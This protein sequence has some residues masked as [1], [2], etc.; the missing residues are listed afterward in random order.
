MSLTVTERELCRELFEPEITTVKLLEECLPTEIFQLLK[1][2]DNLK[3][4]RD[5]ILFFDRNKYRPY[6]S[7]HITKILTN[8]FDCSKAILELVESLTPPFLIYLDMHFTFEI[9]KKDSD[10]SG[11]T[12]L[13]FQ[14]ASKASAFNST[15]KISNLKDLESLTEEIEGKNYSDLL[16]CVFAHHLDLYEYGSSGF[17]PYQLIAL[18][19][20]IQKFPK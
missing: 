20:M 18:Y 7:C 5:K 4:V 10:L 13:K 12:E 2:K 15:F 9:P 6:D 1:E 19:A 14:R 8:H 3:T 17:R 11:K 16:N